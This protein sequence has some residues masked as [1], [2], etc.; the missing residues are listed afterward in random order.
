MLSHIKKNY[1][2]YI[3]FFIII[4]VH[5]FIFQKFFP[6]TNGFV[7]HDYEQFIPNLMFGKIWFSNNFLSIP[8]FTP[9][10]CCGIPFFS[11]PQ[12]M[13]YSIPQIIFLIFDP[14]LSIK[15]TF[16]IFS[17]IGY[18]GM[19]L[20]IKRNFKFNL[21]TSLLCASLFLFNGFFIY[22]S[23]AGHLAY[24][25]YIFVPLYCH[26][27]FESFNHSKIRKYTYLILS[28]IVF[29]NFFH[30]GSGPIIL[31]IF[32]SI[33]S[34]ILIYTELTKNYKIFINF[35]ISLILGVSISLSK[36][37]SSL[38]FL[39]N[40]PRQ[41]LA[42]EFISFSSFIKTFFLSFFIKPN[43]EDFNESINSMFPFGLHEMEYTLS[44]VPL[45]LFLC[46]F[47]IDKKF[48]RINYENLRFVSLLFIIFLFPVL[49]NLNFFDQFR[50]IA[51]I[52]IINSTWVQ[53]RWMAIY[54]IPIIILSGLIFENLKIS[55]FKKKFFLLILISILLTQNYIKD[56]SWYFND[57]KYSLKNAKDFSFQMEKGI[58]PQIIGPAILMEHSGYPKKLNN[59]NDMLFFSYS[60]LLCYQPI[61]GYGLEKLNLKEI[62]FTS[63]QI[64]KDDSYMI[65]S[66]ALETEGENFMFFNPSCF[67]HPEENNCAPGT[68]FKISEK[69]KLIKFIN[70]KKFNFK[71]NIIQTLANYLSILTLSAALLFLLYNFI[72]FIYKFKKKI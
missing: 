27:L 31:I 61:F 72:K 66:N 39:K 1:L 52:P 57:Q 37:V 3:L 53:F 6:N 59:K 68:R 11:D 28:G 10:F 21:Y 45:I 17:V 36:I 62:S 13:Y 4:G 7:G 49:L 38:F 23:I 43:Q 9:S 65:Y 54:I 25:S 22:R 20:L 30:S 26:L 24:L 63:K 15:I 33:I 18:L 60:P 29:A 51:K 12:S 8:W 67:L 40:F 71:L 55:F 35:L 42:T 56:K 69:E 50:I 14:V 34:V 47:F 46:I 32:V 2:F 16:L 41:Y 44:I 64:F 70:Y 58:K 5:Q 48:L 19:F